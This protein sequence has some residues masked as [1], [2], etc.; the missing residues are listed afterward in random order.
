MFSD[1]KIKKIKKNKNL[2]LSRVLCHY[3]KDTNLAQTIFIW[4]KIITLIMPNTKLTCF[5]INDKYC[6]YVVEGHLKQ[7]FWSFTI[8]LKD[9]YEYFLLLEWC[10]GKHLVS[11]QDIFCIIL[12]LHLYLFLAYLKTGLKINR[13]LERTEPQN[14]TYVE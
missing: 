7:D 1:K 9:A 2:F 11:T 3:S 12:Q 14:C 6:Q 5:L 13:R 4:K 8:T 10:E